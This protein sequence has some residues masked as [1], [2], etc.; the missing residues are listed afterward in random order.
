MR[1]EKDLIGE[2]SLDEKLYYGIHTYR[3]KDNFRLNYHN[4]KEEIIKAVILVKKAAAY[5]NYKIEKLSKEKYEIIIEACDKIYNDKKILDENFEICAL[6]GGAGTSINMNANEV[7]ANVALEISGKEKGD[8]SFINPIEDI[9]MSQSTNDVIPTAVKI[10]AIKVLRELVDNVMELQLG[11]QEKEHQFSNVFKIG[12]TQL[13]DAVPITLGDEFGSYAE[14]ISRDRWR[15][16]KMEERIRQVNIGGTAVGTGVGAPLKYRFIITEE[17]R[18]LTEFGM[19][20]AEN[21]IDST[22]NLDVFVEISGLLK[23]LAVN[24]SKI[25]NDLR[26][27]SSGPRAGLNEIELPILQ[28]GSSI[29]PGKV[30]PV[31]AEF[32]KQI[33]YKVVGNDLAITMAAGDGEFE[34]NAMFP[35]IADLIL[36]NLEI[37][38]DGVKIFT[39]KV[40]KGIKANEE[41]CRNYLE[42]SWSVATLL[43]DKIG[44]NKLTEILKEAKIKG[45]TYKE[46]IIEK[47]ILNENEMKNLF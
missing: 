31:G 3:A 39:E 28:A 36:E 34:L 16:Y 41:V 26:L 14:A 23:S 38:R 7:I 43:I 1:K 25:S 35:I 46:I 42:N 10:A 13:Q 44:Y 5:A 21:L 37:L 6:Q 40:I 24:L 22:Q 20:R 11:L 12:R 8:Y 47:N 33:Y 17:I 4:V 29:M 15:L 30:N 19:A 32:I 45:K 18:N 2:E 27:M 9:N